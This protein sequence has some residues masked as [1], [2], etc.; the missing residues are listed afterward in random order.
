MNLVIEYLIR[1]GAIRQFLQTPT[2]LFVEDNS[3]ANRIVIVLQDKPNCPGSCFVHQWYLFEKSEK[4]FLP[5]KQT[6]EISKDSIFEHRQVILDGYKPI[7]FVANAIKYEQNL[8]NQ[9]I[10]AGT[11]NKMYSDYLNSKSHKLH[12]IDCLWDSFARL[13]FDGLL[14]PYK[15]R[16]NKLDRRHVIDQERKYVRMKDR[17]AWLAWEA[18]IKEFL[19]KDG[20]APELIFWSS[21]QKKQLL[22][23]L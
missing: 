17:K 11:Y 19:Q 22:L 23:S 7:K 15:M 18:W 12:K 13:Y 14:A 2:Q 5:Y 4:E 20:V 8:Y 16:L 9:P 21:Y 6:Y 10:E 1:T 3:Q